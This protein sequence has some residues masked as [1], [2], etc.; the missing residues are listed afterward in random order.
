MIQTLPQPPLP[1]R[2]AAEE[3]ESP[4]YYLAWRVRKGHPWRS[5]EFTSRFQAHS[6][7]FSLLDR[8]VE[9]FLEKRQPAF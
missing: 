9:A 2:L 7:Y 1:S 8:G 3:T 6:R 5:E 4:I